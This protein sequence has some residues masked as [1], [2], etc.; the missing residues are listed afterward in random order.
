MAF[1]SS[2][3]IQKRELSNM[4]FCA[5]FVGV[6]SSHLSRETV[7]V[8][9]RQE[10][11]KIQQKIG[12]RSGFISSTLLK[13]EILN[14]FAIFVQHS[15]PLNSTCCEVI[16]SNFSKTSIKWELKVYSY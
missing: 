10:F 4:F 1:L 6:Q 2:K 7:K 11:D 12:K 15:N 14:N 5:C 8:E 9:K 13:K 3:H 16:F